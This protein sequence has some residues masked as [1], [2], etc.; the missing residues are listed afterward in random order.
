[1]YCR[2]SRFITVFL[3]VLFL[4]GICHAEVEVGVDAQ[5]EGEVEVEVTADCNVENGECANPEASSN[6]AEDEVVVE[7]S[8]VVESTVAED[9]HCPSREYVIKCAG[10]YLDTNQNGKLEREELQLAIDKLPWYSRGTSENL[11]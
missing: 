4:V 10:I 1:M 11:K 6:P 3:L 5:M 2:L 7:A 8:E 9:P